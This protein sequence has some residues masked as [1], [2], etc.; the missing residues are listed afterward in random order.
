VSYGYVVAFSCD[1]SYWILRL[2]GVDPWD[3]EDLVAWSK[4]EYIN[5]GSDKQNVIGVHAVGNTITVYAN[6]YPI[7]EVKDDEYSSGRFGVFVSP[8]VT[9]LYTYRVTKV[10]YWVIE[11]E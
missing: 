6:G 3:A 1:G 5:A 8:A 2:D 7:A 9:Q 11:K 4:S 10:A